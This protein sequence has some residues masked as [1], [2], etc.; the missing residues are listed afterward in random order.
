M[1]DLTKILE[2]GHTS[3]RLALKKLTIGRLGMV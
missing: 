3:E 1:A 2:D